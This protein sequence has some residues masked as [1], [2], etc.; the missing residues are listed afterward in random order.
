MYDV[1]IRNGLVYD[2]SGKAPFISDIAVFGDRIALIGRMGITRARRIIDAAG[3]AIFPGFIDIHTHTDLLAINDRNME[4]RLSQ[5]ITTDVSGNCG[6]GV[7]PVSEGLGAAIEDVLGKQSGWQW[8][9]YSGYRNVLLRDGI[10]IN[11]AFLASHTA[12]RLAVMGQRASAEASDEDIE[13]MA[14]MLSSILDEGAWGF[15]SGLYYAPCVFASRKELRRLLEVVRDHG[16]I[17]SV[18][19]RCEGDDVI[20]SLEEVLSLAEE[21]GVRLEIS[22]L[23]AIGRRNQDKVPEM[24]SMI[25]EYRDRGTDVKFDQYPYIFGSTS[26]FSLLPPH[27]LSLRFH[28]LSSVLPC[29]LTTSVMRSEGRWRIPMDGTAYML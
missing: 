29:R 23:K 7:F 21:T 22:H 14:D 11:E 15:S 4:A 24:L 3:K 12:I 27:I 2:G 9:D 13:K 17:F 28:V 16:K 10:G 20:D 1:L 8:S 19:H 5:G 6:I 25:E 18:H 26:L